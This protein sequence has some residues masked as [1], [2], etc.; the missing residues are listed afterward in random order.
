[1]N[2]NDVQENKI[3]VTI[4]NMDDNSEIVVGDIIVDEVIYHEAESI[5]NKDKMEKK[6]YKVKTMGRESTSTST[7][8]LDKQ[9]SPLIVRKYMIENWPL[10]LGIITDCSLSGLDDIV[11]SI[12]DIARN[13][14]M[15]QDDIQ[16]LR[17]FTGFLS[18]SIQKHYDSIKRGSVESVGVYWSC[19]KMVISSLIGDKMCHGMCREEFYFIINTMPH[20]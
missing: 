13:E 8:L 2:A 20:M 4:E 6:N 1:M 16:S 12:V 3:S 17:N 10:F 9:Y 14:G 5:K 19:D 18:D 7:R 11:Y 15:F